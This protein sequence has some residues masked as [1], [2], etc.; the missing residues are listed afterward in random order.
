MPMKLSFAFP[1]KLIKG[2]VEGKQHSLSPASIASRE[3]ANLTQEKNPH[4][5]VYGV[6][7]FVCY[8]I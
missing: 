7:E 2:T 8:Q 6:K 1:P 5:P 3:V 4:A